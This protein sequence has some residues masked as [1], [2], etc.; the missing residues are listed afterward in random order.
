MRHGFMTRM[1]LA[2]LWLGCTSAWP[3]ASTN[4]PNP[5]V[6]VALMSD[7][8]I[9]RGTREEQPFHRGRLERTIAAINAADVDLVL[10]AGDITEDGSRAEFADFR[11]LLKKFRAPVWYVPGNHDLGGKIIVGKRDPK[12]VTPARVETYEWQL[13]PSW[14]CRELPALRVIGLNA[15]LFGSGLAS[16]ARM[17]EFLQKALAASAP[18]PTFVL[19]HNPLY[20]RKANEDGG[21]YWNVEPK[22]RARLLEV[23]RRAG[24]CAV[25]SGHMHTEAVRRQDGILY[26]TTP[27][28]AFGLPKGRQYRGWTLLSVP[29]QGEVQAEF[30]YQV[31]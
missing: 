24:V 5:C 22:P 18:K 25:L 29:A 31:D 14:F 15:S 16:E 8:H 20:T 27:P 23:I 13:G 7:L 6:R 28:V 26:V 3:Q 9:A 12:A 19:L 2:I 21:V 17:W 10:V 4:A 11:K 30:R 1:A